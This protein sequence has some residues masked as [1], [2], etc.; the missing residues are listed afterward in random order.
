[1]TDILIYIHTT[2]RE[3]RSWKNI[4][5][6]LYSVINQHIGKNKTDH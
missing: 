2:H 6:S 5:Q 3:E 1:M 4:I